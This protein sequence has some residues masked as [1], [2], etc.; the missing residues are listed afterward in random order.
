MIDIN[1]LGIDSAEDLPK[2]IVIK[3][4]GTIRFDIEI[5]TGIR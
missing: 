2:E 1:H 3:A 5:D 4:E